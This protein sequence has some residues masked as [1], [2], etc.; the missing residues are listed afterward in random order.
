MIR[1]SA[2]KGDLFFTPFAGSGSECIAAKKAG[3]DFL[4]FEIDKGYVDLANKRL[5][6]PKNQITIEL[7]R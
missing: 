4:G 2:K 3:M 1:L 7:K 6:K 5:N